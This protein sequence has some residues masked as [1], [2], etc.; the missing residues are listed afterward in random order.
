MK[1]DKERT[2]V[3]SV[4]VRS[5]Q[6][7][8][9]PSV[10]PPSMISSVPSFALALRTIRSETVELLVVDVCNK[11]QLLNLNYY[12]RNTHDVKRAAHFV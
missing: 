3:C 9:G 6:A 12:R 10:G 4:R 7:S 2:T 8:I 5:C 11:I 1:I